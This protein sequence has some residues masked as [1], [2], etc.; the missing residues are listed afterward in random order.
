MSN[1]IKYT[2][3]RCQKC[4]KCIRSCPTEAIH[5]RN[6]KVIINNERC[7]YCTKCVSACTSKGLAVTGADLSCLIDPNFNYRVV[8]LPSALYSMCPNLHEVQ[9]LVAAIK[10]IGFD[11]VIDISD[12]EGAVYQKQI[13]FINQNSEDW[14]VS[15]LCP[16]MNKLIQNKY[17]MISNHIIPFDYPLNIKAREIKEKYGDKKV[18][19]YYLAECAGKISLASNK[20]GCTN[21]PVDY[22]ISI[23][24]VFPMIQKNLSDET[25]D[26]EIAADGLRNSI[27]STIRHQQK[28]Q[29]ILAADGLEKASTAL[30]LLEF[31]LLNDIRY[32]S[33]ALC[34]NGCVGGNL[35]W[36]NPF[37]GRMNVE[38]L[39]AQS[40]K[41]N[42]VIKDDKIICQFHKVE[43]VQKSMAERIKEFEAV[44]R[45]L[46]LLPNYDC[47]A[48]GY[49]LCS[50]LAHEI[51]ANRATIEDCVLQ[52]GG[53]RNE[54]K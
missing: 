14:Y 20:Q 19:I 16:S 37:I 24:D 45:Y 44:N 50:T 12:I 8:V 18:G 33:L 28:S 47:G 49:Q 1:I 36:G 48:C 26:F 4:L 34:L 15:S 39:L 25:V 5:V 13:E 29:L 22:T 42:A 7:I 54:S 38:F 30:D 31:D 52:K 6:G 32:L 9:R 21:T 11:E 23:S 35:L 27:T 40:N 3:N 51:Y 10:K 43:I 46:D 53:E 2:L 41:P 17:P